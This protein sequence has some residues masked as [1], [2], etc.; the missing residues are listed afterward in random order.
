MTNKNNHSV[1]RTT[2]GGHVQSNKQGFVH[3]DFPTEVPQWGLEMGWKV[4]GSHVQEETQTSDP[5]NLGPSLHFYLIELR[6]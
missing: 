2:A 1:I 6:T 3:L 4:K 5:R